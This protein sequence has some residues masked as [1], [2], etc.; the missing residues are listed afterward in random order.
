M[1]RVLVSHFNINNFNLSRFDIKCFNIKSML[2][3]VVVFCALFSTGLA[4]AG[5]KVDELVAAQADEIVV[6]EVDFE[7]VVLRGWDKDQIKITGELHEKSKGYTLKQNDGRTRFRVNKQ[8]NVTLRDKGYLEIFIPFGSDVDLAVVNSTA[9]VEHLAG[10]LKVASVNGAVFVSDV[11]KRIT[12]N[13]VNGKITGRVLSGNIVI[14]AVNG[15]IDLANSIGRLDVSTV[16]GTVTTEGRLSNVNVHTVNGEVTLKLGLVERLNVESVN[17]AVNVT[18]ALNENADVNIST[19]NGKVRLALADSSDAKI[20]LKTRGRIKNNFSNDPVKKQQYGPNKW[21]DFVAG[22]G[23]ASVNVSTGGG[24]IVLDR[25]KAKELAGERKQKPFV[26]TADYTEE[27]NNQVPTDDTLQEV[28]DKFFDEF[29]RAEGAALA[30]GARIYIADLE[31]DFSRHWLREHRSR[32]MLKRYQKRIQK[33]FPVLFKKRF[34]KVFEKN[35]AVSVVEQVGDA[36]ILLVPYI[37]KL[38][39]TGPDFQDGTRFKVKQ[40]GRAALALDV[41]DLAS[42]TVIARFYD[43]R[44]TDSA[45]FSYF[46]DASRIYNYREFGQLMTK[47]GARVLDRLEAL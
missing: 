33:D 13:S 2:N 4:L 30:K 12:L 44:E 15:K 27:S 39:I 42:N 29:Y 17:G 7:R 10:P 20:K 23:S 47:W 25:Y 46:E 31:V 38:D 40:A 18:T 9:T 5:E 16:N 14:E 41:V 24:R 19:L 45:G 26:S 36:S 28:K 37:E 1:F 21:L 34:H 35:E 43:S 32:H 6:I 22:N 8:S 11:A 3:G